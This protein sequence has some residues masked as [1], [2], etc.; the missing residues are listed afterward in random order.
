MSYSQILN[1]YLSGL[2]EE[3]YELFLEKAVQIVI[4]EIAPTNPKV[5]KTENINYIEIDFDKVKGFNNLTQEQQELFKSTY[6]VHNS[7][8]GIDYKEEWI[9]VSVKWIEGKPSYLKVVF[10]NRDWLHYTLNGTWY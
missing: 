2:N 7:V 9:P 4:N 6:R 8:H 10:R 1:D 5:V 3:E